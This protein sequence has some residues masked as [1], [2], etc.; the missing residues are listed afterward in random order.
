MPSIRN[1]TYEDTSAM[2]VELKFHTLIAGITL[3]NDASVRLH[4]SMGMKKIGTFPEVGW[5]FNSWHDVGYWV[6]ILTP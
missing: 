1:A 5:K 6:K 3:P 4:E 2:L